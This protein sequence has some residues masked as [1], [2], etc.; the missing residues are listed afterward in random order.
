MSVRDANANNLADV[1]DFTRPNR[2]AAQ[3]AVP[4]G[5][6]GVPCPSSE[7]N[8]FIVLRDLAAGFGFPVWEAR[9]VGRVATFLER[10][11]CYGRMVSPVK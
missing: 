2:K 6:F 9:D 1:M 4:R 7:A 3:Y 10:A 11:P 5:P 8:P